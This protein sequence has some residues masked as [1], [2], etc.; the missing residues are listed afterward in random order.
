M[1]EGD[2]VLLVER[3]RTWTKIKGERDVAIEK[4][5]MVKGFAWGVVIA[6]LGML[7]LALYVRLNNLPGVV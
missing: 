4:H 2:K 1:A 6:L 5:G 3:K 7:L